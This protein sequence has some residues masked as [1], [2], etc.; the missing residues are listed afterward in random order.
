MPVSVGPETS[1]VTMLAYAASAFD[2]FE[3]RPLG[4]A[5]SLVFSQLAMVRIGDLIEPLSLDAPQA[6]PPSWRA[7]LARRLGLRPASDP[8][9][10]ARPLPELLRAEH[11]EHMFTGLATQ[12]TREL[13]HAV[14]ASPRFREVRVVFPCEITRAEP[15]EQFA[16]V[17]FVYKDLFSYV[18]FRGTDVSVTGWR[19]NV[20]MAYEHPI[21][22]QGDAER[23]L[24]AVT[25]LVPGSLVVGG[26][27]KGGNL[28]VYAAVQCLDCIQER[29]AAVYNHDGP[30]FIEGILD[31]ARLSALAGRIHKSVPEASVV[32]V[33]LDPGENFSIIQSAGHGIEQH[34]TFLWSIDPATGDL[35]R[36]ESLADSAKLWQRALDQWLNA[37]TPQEIEHI[38]QALSAVLQA[39]GD[40]DV[41]ILLNGGP[42]AWNLLLE[43]ARDI[44]DE[45][46][47]LLREALADLGSTAAHAWGSQIASD[48]QQRAHSVAAGAS[49]LAS[50]VWELATGTEEEKAR[51]RKAREARQQG[52]SPTQPPAP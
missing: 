7:Q 41:E 27:S 25:P 10:S 44:G 22:G 50:V 1:P 29:L 8:L 2:S 15:P 51:A 32:G 38:G 6:A 49:R 26:H 43:S 34:G 30:G 14:A 11:Y 31:P 42:A 21:A 36:A 13:L 20:C 40:E 16:A 3:D 52:G 33:T 24:E 9:Q 4:E 23:Y 18:A 35:V 37:R 46:R 19:E 5:D 39:T 28:A 47:I 45:D 48:V 17:T 12:Q